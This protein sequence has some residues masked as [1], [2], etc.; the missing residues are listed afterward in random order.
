MFVERVQR[1]DE[2]LQDVR[3]VEDVVAGVA[4]GYLGCLGAERGDL[5]GEDGG[6]MEG[7]GLRHGGSVH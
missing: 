6:E 5:C 7:G 1:L 2:I 3:L 4:V